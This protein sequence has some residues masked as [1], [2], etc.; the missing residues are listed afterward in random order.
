MVLERS[1]TGTGR[2]TPPSARVP[3]QDIFEA[4][5]PTQQEVRQSAIGPVKLKFFSTGR[6]GEVGWRLTIHDLRGGL[7]ANKGYVEEVHARTRSGTLDTRYKGQA[8][9]HQLGASQSTPD[10]TTDPRFISSLN[11]FSKLLIGVGA[12]ADVSLLQ[13]TSST[14]PALTGITFTPNGA[15][16]GLAPITIGGIAAGERLA[17]LSLGV[18]EVIGPDLVSDGDMHVNTTDCWAMMQVPD[19]DRTILFFTAAGVVTLTAASAI[20]DAPTATTV[21]D[22]PEG[23]FGLGVF[24]LAGRPVRP[25]IVIPRTDSSQGMN[26][27]GDESLGDIWHFNIRGTD[28]QIFPLPL[29]GIRWAGRFREG[30]IA[31]DEERIVYTNGLILRDTKFDENRPANSDRRILARSYYVNGGGELIVNVESIASAN[32]TGNTQFWRERYDFDLDAWSQISAV[33]TFSTTGRL[34]YAG[35]GPMPLSNQNGFA[36]AY[37]DG[38][39]YRLFLPKAGQSPYSLRQSSGAQA[40]TGVQFEASGA[41]DS[42]EYIFPD[43]LAWAPKVITGMGFMGELDEG[44]SGSTLSLTCGGKEHTFRYGYGAAAQWW[45]FKDSDYRITY[46]QISAVLTRGSSAYMTPQ[47]LPI[48]IEGIAYL[49][50]PGQRKPIKV[51]R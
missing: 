50:E 20:G 11:L 6:A 32:G 19:P 10:P 1:G 4:A 45:D 16:A 36:H 12:G 5:R 3:G 21:T 24:G 34:T 39:W 42:P 14:N 7:Q 23:G 51:P 41:W 35:A 43:E 18:A 33:T 38:S 15:I 47:M 2:Y 22:L 37:G 27:F 9:L 25:W 40:T 46:P 29:K 44:G 31:S 17:V 8:V 26:K 28:P 49:E 13:E 30:I 48:V